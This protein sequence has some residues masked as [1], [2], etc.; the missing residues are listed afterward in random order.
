V[1]WKLEN[2]FHCVTV[3]EAKNS[4][5]LGL[6]CRPHWDSRPVSPDSAGTAP[7]PYA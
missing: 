1:S 7:S 3:A 6:H 4:E 2:T 5:L